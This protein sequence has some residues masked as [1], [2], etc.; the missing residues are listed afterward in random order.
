MTRP[1]LLFAIFSLIV[2]GAA[3]AKGAHMSINA[4]VESIE[5]V[6]DSLEIVF[7]GTISHVSGDGPGNGDQWGFAA[8]VKQTKLIIPDAKLAYFFM[9]LKN[10]GMITKNF[11]DDLELARKIYGKRKLRLVLISAYGP[12]VHFGEGISKITSGSATFSLLADTMSNTVSIPAEQEAA[13]QPR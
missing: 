11:K 9:T 2:S 1:L 12:V 10:G 8:R 5:L 13:Q 3:H 7:H 6:G 4:T